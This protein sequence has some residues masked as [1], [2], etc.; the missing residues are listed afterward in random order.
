MS[1]EN[2]EVQNRPYPYIPLLGRSHLGFG[3][4]TSEP[5]SEQRGPQRPSAAANRALG[6]LNLFVL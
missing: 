5:E 4:M 3:H 2:S 6:L 1:V